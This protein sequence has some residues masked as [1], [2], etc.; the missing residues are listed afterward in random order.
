MS[1]DL[2]LSTTELDIFRL[3]YRAG[4]T[5]AI[6]APVSYSFLAGVGVAFSTGARHKLEDGAIVR[7][8]T[9]LHVHIGPGQGASVSTQ[10]ATL[11]R[12]LIHGA[13]H[14]AFQRVAR[15][16]SYRTWAEPYILTLG[17]RF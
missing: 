16:R 6:S 1:S 2:E 13:K 7:S 4:V 11:R 14:G 5:T 10:I 12:L 8:A 17:Y 9:A 15:V 3:A